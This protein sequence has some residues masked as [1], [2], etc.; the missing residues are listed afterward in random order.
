MFS[1]KGRLS[2]WQ[3][4]PSSTHKIHQK[5]FFQWW[6][7]FSKEF[8]ALNFTIVKKEISSIMRYNQRFPHRQTCNQRRRSADHHLEGFLRQSSSQVICPR[9]NLRLKTCQSFAFLLKNQSKM[10]LLQEK[11]WLR[12]QRRPHCPLFVRRAALELVRPLPISEPWLKIVWVLWE[13]PPRTSYRSSLRV[14][15]SRQILIALL[16]QKPSV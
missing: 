9:L 12:N 10:T 1:K 13:S 2:T 14:R 4:L 3:S 15:N 5:C 8:L 11:G 7:C 6:V 16:L